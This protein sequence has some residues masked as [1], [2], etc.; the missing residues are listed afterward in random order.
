MKLTKTP[1]KPLPFSDEPDRLAEIYRVAAQLICEKGYDATS[2]NDIAEAV[3][4]TKAGVYH[5]IQGKKDLLF[6]IMNFGMDELDE[7]VIVPARAIPDAEARLRAIIANHVRLITRHVTPQGYNPVTIVVDELA[8]LTPEHRRKISHRKRA[9]V[10][11]IRETLKQLKEEGKLREVD[12][13]VAAFSLLGTIL[14]LS[15]WY[16]PDGR[17][18]PEEVIAEIVKLALGGL[19]RPQARSVTTI[20]T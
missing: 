16:H 8:G 15:R 17:L 10:D 4:I 11:L 5:H 20:V 13:T 19:L 2:M 6:R 7:N 14:W 9:Y 3:G 12:V 1:F 18:T